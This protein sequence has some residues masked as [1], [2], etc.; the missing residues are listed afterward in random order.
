MLHFRLD[1]WRLTSDFAT[2]QP[3]FLIPTGPNEVFYHDVPNAQYWTDL[4]VKHPRAAQ[5]DD[6]VNHEA[7]REV[8]VTSLV[9]E[10][11]KALPAEV[12][13]MMIGR[14]EEQG[15]EMKVESAGASHSVFLS[16][17]EVVVEVVG[18]A[19]A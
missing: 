8:P 18:R 12:Q 11:D 4:L 9:C 1:A 17:P 10:D 6:V 16:M 13:R 14:I 5:Y 3:P 15:V 7:F 2:L 19:A